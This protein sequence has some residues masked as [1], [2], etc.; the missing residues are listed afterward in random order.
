ML[1]S[2]DDFVS[3]I[4][5]ADSYSLSNQ[6]SSFMSTAVGPCILILALQYMLLINL[7]TT[8]RMLEM[9]VTACFLCY[10][11]VF[12]N[13]FTPYIMR[14]T[15]NLLA[16]YCCCSSPLKITFVYCNGILCT[17]VVFC[18]L[19]RCSVHNTCGIF[20][21]KLFYF[22]TFCDVL[23]LIVVFCAAV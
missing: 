14:T 23:C 2:A 9:Y 6:Y 18:L 21:V 22:A 8:A 3:C 1:F 16:V 4:A 10:Y 5:G 13:F 12:I 20:T 11:T 7:V 15:I 19:L 17:T